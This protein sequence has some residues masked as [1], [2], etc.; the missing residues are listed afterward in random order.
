M[1][2]SKLKCIKRNESVTLCVSCIVHSDKVS[3][4]YHEHF[5]TSRLLGTPFAFH[6]TTNCFKRV[7]SQKNFVMLFM[8]INYSICDREVAFIVRE[9]SRVDVANTRETT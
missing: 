4:C 7:A 3:L 1:Y 9:T 8:A 2:L 6:R 5:P